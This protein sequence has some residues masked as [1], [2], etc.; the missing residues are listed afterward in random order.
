MPFG[1]VLGALLGG[2]GGSAEDMS[3]AGV[4][5][6]PDGKAIL[7]LLNLKAGSILNLDS[8]AEG[9]AMKVSA[10]PIDIIA[11]GDFDELLLDKPGI[12]GSIDSVG[13]VSVELLFVDAGPNRA[14]ANQSGLIDFAGTAE[15]A[16]QHALLRLQTAGSEVL[17]PVS[18]ADIDGEP[19]LSIDADGRAVL[20]GVGSLLESFG[21]TMGIEDDIVERPEITSRA[22]VVVDDPEKLVAFLKGEPG[23]EKLTSSKSGIPGAKSLADEMNTNQT[24]N[25]PS[26]ESKQS[27][28]VKIDVLRL[29]QADAGARTVKPTVD[30]AVNDHVRNG[31]LAANESIDALKTGGRTNVAGS[32][33]G[34]E[35]DNIMSSDRGFKQ[36]F[37]GTQANR[38]ADHDIK[39]ASGGREKIDV[40]KMIRESSSKLDDAI[41]KN[42]KAATEV[43]AKSVDSS[44]KLDL[45]RSQL[46]PQMAEVRQEMPRTIPEPVKFK[47]ELANTGLKISDISTFKISIKPEWL[48]TVKVHLSM[49]EDHLSAKLSVESNTAR[50][51]VEANLPALREVLSQHGIKVDTFSVDVA[52]QGQEERQFAEEKEQAPKD[53]NESSE[54]FSLDPDSYGD[55]PMAAVR[56]AAPVGNLSGRLS[57][58]A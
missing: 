46:R 51:A 23:P 50:N 12:G 47:L 6:N 14:H 55:A 26:S 57:M 10:L 38:H 45:P 7:D 53:P 41:A 48:G 40:E 56:K 8:L 30:K 18:L 32:G 43:E 15:N 16:P 34:A 29:V 36:T 9:S 13:K 52:D 58:V 37:K 44:S 24:K 1:M 39:P 11:D 35:H 49:V 20:R 4:L 2:N 25:V 28:P 19:G 27:E 22:V 21:L 42:S 5:A 31:F 3:E 33:V 54:K 17:V